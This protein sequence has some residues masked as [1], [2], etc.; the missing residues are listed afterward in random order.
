MSFVDQSAT[1]EDLK[2]AILALEERVEQRA[3][4]R[5]QETMLEIG[6]AV[7]SLAERVEQRAQARHQ[8]TML[9]IGRA[10]SSVAE[11]IGRQATVVDEKY[12]EL[13]GQVAALRADLD[14]HRSDLR[15]H[16]PAPAPRTKRKR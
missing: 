8:E 15:I 3:Q 16:R 10:V 11:I 5:H 7:N 2:E 6:R 9:E 12:Q 4:A 13:P 1:K 14:E